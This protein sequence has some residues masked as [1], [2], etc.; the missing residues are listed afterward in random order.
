MRATRSGRRSPQVLEPGVDRRLVADRQV[1]GGADARRRHGGD[2]V[3]IQAQA[4]QGAD[5]L[6]LQLAAQV[7]RAIGGRWN[8][9][10]GRW[11]SRRSRVGAARLMLAPSS[12]AR[13]RPRD[14]PD[15]RRSRP[16]APPSSRTS[17][18]RPAP[19]APRITGSP[20]RSRSGASATIA[21]WRS[22][23]TMS[24]GPAALRS[25]STRSRRSTH[26]LPPERAHRRGLRRAAHLQGIPPHRRR[27]PGA[28]P[29]P[30]RD[31]MPSRP[32][33]A[34]IRSTKPRVGWLGV[35]HTASI[36]PPRRSPANC[37]RCARR[38]PTGS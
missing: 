22:N 28:R 24:T 9:G 37:G 33:A 35:R 2:R 5:G 25:A 11:S 38:P 21:P 3:G 26:T 10:T 20:G 32:S 12:R 34:L 1:F 31:R 30:D 36:R 16:G 27:R 23:S 19:P 17:T 29:L 13:L 6:L 15:S 4:R 18:S 14:D 7:E 8:D